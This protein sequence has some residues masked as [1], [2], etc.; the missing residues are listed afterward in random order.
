MARK[1]E[2]TIWVSELTQRRL[3]PVCVKSGRT[4]D[5]QMTFEFEQP[6]STGWLLAAV[7]LSPLTT[8]AGPGRARGHLPLTRRWHRILQ[9]SRSGAAV[10]APIGGVV[11]LTSGMPPA[12]W[13]SGWLGLGFGL[14]AASV[15]LVTIY[16]GLKPKGEV[17]KTPQGE[18]WLR[19]IHPNFASAIGALDHGV[20]ATPPPAGG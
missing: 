20:I 19:D 5:S 15:V 1:A 17:F 13:R 4:A 18:R 10:A 2:A 7:M 3:P 6:Q 11:L 9:G 8:F 14:L 16:G 12:A